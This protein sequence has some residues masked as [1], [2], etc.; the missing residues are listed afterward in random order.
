VVYN[1]E[2]AIGDL[3]ASIAALLNLKQFSDGPA[4]QREIGKTAL[5]LLEK[6]KKLDPESRRE[7]QKELE[8]A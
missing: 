1:R 2:F 8:E 7:I 5:F 6:I 4:F 3:S